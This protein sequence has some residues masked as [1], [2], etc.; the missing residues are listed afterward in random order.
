MNDEKSDTS[1]VID[2][3]VALSA[4][5]R[6]SIDMQIATAK[7]YPRSIDKALKEAQTLAT[8]DEETAG[9]MFYAL[10]RDGKMIEGPSARLAEIMAYA[11]GNLRVDSDIVGEDKT[12]ITAMGTCF[13]LEKNV[14]IRVRVRRRI[15]DRQGR[16]YKDDMIGV[17]GNA[18]ISIALRNAVFKVIP[19]ALVRRVYLGARNASLGQGGTMA[20]KRAK[21][22]AWFAKLGIAEQ[23]VFR[24][25]GVRGLD[26]IGEDHL[27]ALRGMVNAIQDGDTTAEQVF[28][29][30]KES[31]E[32]SQNA[33]DLDA[34]LSQPATSKPKAAGQPEAEQ[35]EPAE[36]PEGPAEPDAAP[37][38]QAPAWQRF[39][40]RCSTLKATLGEE[41]YYMV[42]ADFQVTHANQIA[43]DDLGGMRALVEALETKTRDQG[44]PVDDGGPGQTDHTDDLTLAL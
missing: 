18:A 23:D 7:Q 13:D 9:S 24:V 32:S 11:W 5:D 20:Q 42:L 29:P 17:T 8:L 1:I 26:D 16:R 44:E 31:G 27:I 4:V 12:H 35:E 10:P 22:M 34:A 2:P 30:P 37:K 36:A 15:T 3:S 28:A 38:R 21:A 6:A 43:R 40:R 19:A 14:A 39:L 25:L 41:R 33:K